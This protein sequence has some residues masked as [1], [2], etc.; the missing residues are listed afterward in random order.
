MRLW[1]LHPRY[2]DRQGLLGCWREAL[3]AQKVLNGLTRGYTRHPQLERF[4]SCPDPLAAVAT[5]L[6]GLAD[7][8]ERR[9]YHFDGSKIPP[10]RFSGTLQVTEGQV[11]LEWA[12]LQEKLARRDPAWLANLPNVD[13]PDCHPLFVVMLGEVEP[14]ER[15]QR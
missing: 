3:L 1:S 5:F 14:W 11:R 7:E 9:G 12:H 6:A 4:R 8:A 10:Q 13:L 15:S 2:L